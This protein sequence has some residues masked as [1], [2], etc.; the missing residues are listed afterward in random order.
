MLDGRIDGVWSRMPQ[1]LA[2]GSA[3][4][5]QC[6]A[7]A[8]HG[9]RGRLLAMVHYLIRFKRGA[10]TR[11]TSRVSVPAK[12]AYFHLINHFWPFR[13]SLLANTASTSKK[14]LKN[15]A[16]QEVCVARSS[17]VLRGVRLAV[18]IYKHICLYTMCALRSSRLIRKGYT[19][20]WLVLDRRLVHIR[21]ARLD[22]EWYPNYG[23][24]PVLEPAQS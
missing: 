24:H 4:Q 12:C 14:V 17:Y 2:C 15:S 16:E 8:C 9:N 6:G 18:C 10:L 13:H 23:E 7:V 5:W 22:A 20:I 3:W 21:C 19:R 1:L 11:C